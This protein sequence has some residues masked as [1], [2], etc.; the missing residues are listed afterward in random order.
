[1]T[2]VTTFGSTLAGLNR[3]LVNATPR[4]TQELVWA[5]VA[6]LRTAL[7]ELP[8]EGSAAWVAAGVALRLALAAV[9]F[10]ALGWIFINV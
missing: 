1:M 9:P 8:P 4:L 6:K 3:P 10:A 7:P 2:Q 5:H